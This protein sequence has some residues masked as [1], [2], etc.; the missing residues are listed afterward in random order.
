MARN[1]E[2]VDTFPVPA[3]VVGAENDVLFLNA[4][5]KT[6]VMGCASNRGSCPEQLC[7]IGKLADWTVNQ[8]LPP[9]LGKLPLSRFFDNTGIKAVIRSFDLDG[10]EPARLVLLFWDESTPSLNGELLTQLYGLTQAEGRL[11]AQMVST[12]GSPKDISD[13][14]GISINT[15][16]THMKRIFAKVGV[17]GQVDLVRRIL[18]G[19]AVYMGT[20]DA[21]TRETGRPPCNL[22]P[23][24][25]RP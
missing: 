1:F 13:S 12:E 4:V 11:A 17:P 16:R 15:V 18:N 14:L 22:I 20:N 6:A 10:E 19:P 9:H 21:G 25:I 7:I 2:I 5:A 23:F 8:S 24:G 3:L